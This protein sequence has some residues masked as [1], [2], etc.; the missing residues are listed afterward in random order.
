MMERARENARQAGVTVR[1]EA[2]GFGELA[3][4]FGERCFNALLCLGNSLP[5]LLSAG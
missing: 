4:T 2:A 3:V 5:H 1:F